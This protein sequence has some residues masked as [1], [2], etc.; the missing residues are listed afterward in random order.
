[1]LNDEIMRFILLNH[2][3]NDGYEFFSTHVFPQLLVPQFLPFAKNVYLS[4]SFLWLRWSPCLINN[5]V[6]GE[7]V[8]AN[9]CWT[10][11][12]WLL[13]QLKKN[14]LHHAHFIENVLNASWH[15]HWL[16]YCETPL[17]PSEIRL[18]N[19]DNI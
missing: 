9:F 7:L 18:I 15:S 5:N 12:W 3:E 13:Q 17:Q 8:N 6:V 4:F 1:M 16:F 10:S 19:T 2:N 14:E 11:R